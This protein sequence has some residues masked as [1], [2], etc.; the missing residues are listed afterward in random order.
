MS[1]RF[2]GNCPA[3]REGVRGSSCTIYGNLAWT[4]APRDPKDPPE[5]PDTMD[6]LRPDRC[7]AKPKNRAQTT[8]RMA[9]IRELRNFR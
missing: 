9:E 6:M 8:H 7:K 4:T 3:R 2:C 5:A 1:R